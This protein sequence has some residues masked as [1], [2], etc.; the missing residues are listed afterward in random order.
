MTYNI[1]ETHIHSSMT[2][3]S[4]R[5]IAVAGILSAL[6]A[7]ALI[8]AS[9]ASLRAQLSPPPSI[10]G[11]GMGSSFSFSSWLCSKVDCGGIFGM[12]SGPIPGGTVPTGPAPGMGIPGTTGFLPPAPGYFSP[13]PST[14]HPSA[15]GPTGGNVGGMGMPDGG[16]GRPEL[17]G[18]GG[19]NGGDD[20]MTGRDDGTTDDRGGYDQFPGGGGGWDE[21]WRSNGGDGGGDDGGPI[22]GYGGLNGGG[23]G[24]IGGGGLGGGDGGMGDG[25]LGGDGDRGMGGD[26]LGGGGGVSDGGGGTRDGGNAGQ[27]CGNGI[28]EYPE[29]EN[30]QNDGDILCRRDCSD[31][32]N[33]GDGDNRGG[34]DDDGNSDG[35]GNDGDDRDGGDDDNQAMGTCDGEQAGELSEQAE[36]N[37]GHRFGNYFLRT[38]WVT[39]RTAKCPAAKTEL[40]PVV[41]WISTG[42]ICR[43]ITEGTFIK[44]MVNPKNGRTEH[45]YQLPNDEEEFCGGPSN[46]WRID[47]REYPVSGNL[48]YVKKMLDE[49]QKMIPSSFPIEASMRG[50][51][52]LHV[53]PDVTDGEGKPSHYLLT[54]FDRRANTNFAVGPFTKAG[55]Q[56]P[57]Y[58]LP[59]KVSEVPIDLSGVLAE[60]SWGIASDPSMNKLKPGKMTF[61]TADRINV[62]YPRMLDG[63]E[64]PRESTVVLTLRDPNIYEDDSV[65]FVVEDAA[66]GDVLTEGIYETK[67]MPQF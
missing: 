1:H 39:G 10:G 18:N 61:I 42:A 37:T 47:A 15:F 36:R 65:H 24:G 43:G 5:H 59:G 12:P 63:T 31:D 30:P 41:D 56:D 62:V 16:P 54:S 28:C 34:S 27:R 40:G 2:H 20:G 11:A 6:L 60:W 19:L 66:T 53:I 13:M 51:W 48:K 33:S 45:L 7:I 22:G 67:N 17:G 4:R 64:I 29:T 52:T 25:G 35:G 32:G 38:S 44:K 58:F 50:N 49:A 21:A 14:F 55:T 9:S 57:F 23:D 8:G 3:R 46:G 26:G